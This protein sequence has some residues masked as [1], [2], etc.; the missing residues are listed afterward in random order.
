VARAVECAQQAGLFHTVMVSTDDETI[1]EVA[2]RAGGEVPFMREASLAQDT[3][4]VT[5]VVRNVI[6]W[7][8]QN[9]GCSFDWVCILQPTSP[10]RTP[11]D[12]SA[13]WSL[14]SDDPEITAVISVSP[15]HHHPHWA[16]GV[17]GGV[18]QPAF[19]AQARASRQD[20]PEL[21]HP[22][23]AVY[24]WKT[25]MMM[26]DENIY[27]GRP[28]PYHTPHESALDIDY[29]EDLIFAEW[30]VSSGRRS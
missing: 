17:R 28:L 22:D 16:V 24:W 11:E 15:Y 12:I 9:R 29:P 14:V 10:L 6:E 3:V 7:Y 1:A 4:E 18:L 21:Y 13:S 2:R 20:L 30:L 8:E 5:P 25:A 19:P 26:Q 27:N 23:G